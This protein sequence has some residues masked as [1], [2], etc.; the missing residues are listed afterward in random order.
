[1]NE[2]KNREN[3]QKRESRDVS[4]RKPSACVLGKNTIPTFKIV[5]FRTALPSTGFDRNI[6]YCISISLWYFVF[7][8]LTNPCKLKK[9][10]IKGIFILIYFKLS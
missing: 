7:I 5:W 1:M 4:E 2:H 8:W 6:L 10:R 3:T 9:E